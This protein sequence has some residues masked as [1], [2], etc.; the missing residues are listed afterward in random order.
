M[1]IRAK[2]AE[3]TFPRR[4]SRSEPIP[5]R[6]SIEQFGAGKPRQ[7]CKTGFGAWLSPVE[8]C[9]RV[10]EV[11][12]SNPGAPIRCPAEG[13]QGVDA[14]GSVHAKKEFGEQPGTRAASSGRPDLVSAE[15]GQ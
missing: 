5:P 13:G 1:V 7:G 8:R 6:F 2:R 12:G 11:P 14:P 15:G 9:V 3:R 4:G 10:A